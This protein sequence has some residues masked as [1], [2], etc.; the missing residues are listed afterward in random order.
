MQFLDVP[1]SLL[2][3]GYQFQLAQLFLANKKVIRRY[4]KGRQVFFLL[5][6]CSY[7]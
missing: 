6:L 7:R 4:V 2:L 3:V 1:V 5:G